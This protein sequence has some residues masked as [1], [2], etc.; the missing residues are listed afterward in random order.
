MKIV[1]KKEFIM[2]KLI[3]ISIIFVTLLLSACSGT[4]SRQDVGMVAGG[5]VGGVAVG[6]L[7]HGN[8]VGAV[9]GAIGGGLVGRELAQ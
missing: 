6:A 2:K 7:T 8:P 1:Q 3:S 9:A 5:V 4:T